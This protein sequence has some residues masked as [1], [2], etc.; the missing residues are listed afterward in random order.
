M[1]YPE[2]YKPP[3]DIVRPLDYAPDERRVPT[4]VERADA[5]DEERPQKLKG[6]DQ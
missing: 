1:A 4:P 3:A 5:R 2:S 6:E